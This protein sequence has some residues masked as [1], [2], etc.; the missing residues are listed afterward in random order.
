MAMFNGKITMFN[1]KIHYKW[2]VSIAILVKTRWYPVFRQTLKW[3][4]NARRAGAEPVLRAGFP[5]PTI[6][7]SVGA[8]SILFISNLSLNP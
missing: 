2:Q 3:S 6:T 1:G 4:G 5:P 7:T 8:C